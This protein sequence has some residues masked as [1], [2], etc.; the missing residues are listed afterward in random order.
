MVR[1]KRYLPMKVRG[2]E[3]MKKILILS[4]WCSVSVFS[5]TEI[6][7][8]PI[9]TSLSEWI[10]EINFPPLYVYLEETAEDKQIKVWPQPKEL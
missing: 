5:K 8:A 6:Y 9:E 2:T 7:F 4:L 10:N 3:E 1:Q